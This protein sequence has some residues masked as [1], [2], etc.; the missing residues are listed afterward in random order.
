M[1]GPPC[2]RPISLGQDFEI[3]EVDAQRIVGHDPKLLRFGG[4]LFW[5]GEGMEPEN[6]VRTIHGRA[7]KLK[8]SRSIPSM[9]RPRVRSNTSALDRRMG[10]E[11]RPVY[12]RI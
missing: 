5:V 7:T 8:K 10:S 4:D 1:G 9:R 2:A 6:D 11:L 3:G 12:T